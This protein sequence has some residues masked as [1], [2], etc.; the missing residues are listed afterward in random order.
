LGIGG[1]LYSQEGDGLDFLDKVENIQVPKE[2]PVEE[3]PKETTTKTVA[4]AQTSTDRQPTKTSTKAT[5]TSQPVRKPITTKPVA[6]PDK[7]PV[8]TKTTYVPSKPI[9]SKPPIEKEEPA[10]EEVQESSNAIWINEP[11][12]M[13]PDYLP[14]FEAMLVKE[15]E[16]KTLPLDEKKEN[17]RPDPV[18][19]GDFS[20]W[21]SFTGFLSQYQ[22][23]FYIFGILLLFAL[24]R[25]RSGRASSSARRSSPT[26]RRMRR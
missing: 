8:K 7:T 13:D 5:P 14:G 18:V 2:K 1:N 19:T 3:A 9:R 6:T 15:E 23:A 22:K 21:E 20:I 11:L 26:I 10:V 12:A 16:P 25:L 17:F 4:P 24:Y